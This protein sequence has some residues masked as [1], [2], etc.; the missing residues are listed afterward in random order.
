MFVKGCALL[1]PMIRFKIDRFDSLIIFEMI[2]ILASGQLSAILLC[3]AAGDR[4]AKRE[5]ERFTTFIQPAWLMRTGLCSRLSLLPQGNK[6][7]ADSLLVLV[8]HEQTHAPR[9]ILDRVR[10]GLQEIEG[11]PLSGS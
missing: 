11:S 5:R 4:E 2:P 8:A 1:Q 3:I 10:Q 7:M 9:S 6:T